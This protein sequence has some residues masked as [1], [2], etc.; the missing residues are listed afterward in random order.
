MPRSVLQIPSDILSCPL[1]LNENSG[2]RGRLI[3]APAG[4]RIIPRPIQTNLRNPVQTLLHVLLR[5]HRRS[6]FILHRSDSGIPSSADKSVMRPVAASRLS[7][8]LSRLH[9]P[10]SWKRSIRHRATGSN[11]A[12]IENRSILGVRPYHR[13]LP[14]RSRAM[15]YENQ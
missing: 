2:S 4:S 15:L 6:P 8:L 1:E 13:T 10:I 9:D 12:S 5:I 14:I 11:R 7:G 3:N